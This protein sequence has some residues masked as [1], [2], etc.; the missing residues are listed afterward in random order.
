MADGTPV[1]IVLNPLGVPSRMN[2]GQ[3]LETHLGWAAEGP[4]PEDRRMLDAQAKVADLRKLPRRDLQPRQ[5]RRPAEREDLKQFSDEE[6]TDAGARTCRRACRWRP[7]CSTAP[8][9]P[10]SSTC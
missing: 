7:R 4:G 8:P 2:I 5:P 3:V 6:I 10:R 9:R 1:D